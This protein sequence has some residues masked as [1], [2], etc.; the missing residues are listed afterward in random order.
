M[1]TITEFGHKNSNFF[2]YR[3]GIKGSIVVLLMNLVHLYCKEGFG[4]F[5]RLVI[6]ELTLMHYRA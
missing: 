1:I 2:W 3:N 6:F 5:L 4:D